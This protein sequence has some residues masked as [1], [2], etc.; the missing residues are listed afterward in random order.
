MPIKLS[1][2]LNPSELAHK[3]K[4]KSA[5]WGF[6]KDDTGRTVAQTIDNNL[7]RIDPSSVRSTTGNHN[8]IPSEDTKSTERVKPKPF[9]AIGK[10]ISAAN[11]KNLDS[12]NP[13]SVTT[14]SS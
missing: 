9:K 1:N 10:F 12:A 8:E 5:G 13:N 7:V 3:L 2:L 14:I 4:L 6:W 11:V